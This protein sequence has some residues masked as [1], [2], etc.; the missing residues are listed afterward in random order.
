MKVVVT[1]ARLHLKKMFDK[2][3]ARQERVK[4]V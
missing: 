3:N 4:K 2:E 1:R